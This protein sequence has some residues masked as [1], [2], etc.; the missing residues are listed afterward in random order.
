MHQIHLRPELRQTRW[1]APHLAGTSDKEGRQSAGRT[2]DLDATAGGPSDTRWGA[3]H[4]AGTSGK[5][6]RQSAGR[7][8]DPDATDLRAYL[9]VQT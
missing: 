9:A 2:F 8:F 1:G 4:M 3:P 6:G 7:T 5:E